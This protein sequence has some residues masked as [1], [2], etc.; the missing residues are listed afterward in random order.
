M[1]GKGELNP[2]SPAIPTLEVGLF[3][4]AQSPHDLRVVQ[5]NA[6]GGNDKEHRIR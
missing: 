1:N 6:A 3:Y 5:Q 2:H 4:D